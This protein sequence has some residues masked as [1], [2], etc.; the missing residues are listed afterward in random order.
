MGDRDRSPK[1]D[2]RSGGGGPGARVDQGK[3]RKG[4]ADKRI[5]VSNLPYE[6][7]WQEVKDLFRQEV[8]E[9]S[10]VELF[11]DESG[12]PRGA[13]VMEFPTQDMARLAIDKMHRYDYK[14]RKI[15]VKEDF[16]AERDKQGRIVGRSGVGDR[17]GGD[18]RGGG[19][20]GHHESMGGGLGP[21]GDMGNTYGLSPQFLASLNIQGPLHTRVFVANM[22]YT[23]DERKLKEVFRLA[24]RVVGVEL[25]RDKEGKS[26]GFAVVV[27]DHPVEAVQAICMLNGQQLCDR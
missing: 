16:D 13:G 27:Y 10:Y 7:K 14:G 19:P 21:G 15:V 17:G 23:V 18:R 4:P 26:R 9:V 20:A 12:K 22:D 6:M 24:G 1:R 11:N 25:Q 3:M 8:G 2:R 5:F